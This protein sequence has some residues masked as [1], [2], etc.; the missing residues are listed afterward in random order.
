MAVGHL[1]WSHGCKANIFGSW[2]S[3]IHD[4]KL[5]GLQQIFCLSSGG[6]KSKIK[7]SAALI[8]PGGSD[9]ETTLCLFQLLVLLTVLGIPGLVAVSLL[10][11]PLSS[12]SLLPVCLCVFS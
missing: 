9:R 3:H 8:P 12:H 2:G 1:G 5:G 4:C 7:V 6:R 10:A 11:L